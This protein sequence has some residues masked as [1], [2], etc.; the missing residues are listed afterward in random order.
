MDEVQEGGRAIAEKR[1]TSGK[2]GN[3]R[4][5]IV[6][7][8]EMCSSRRELKAAGQV[9]DAKKRQERLAFD[10]TD[11]QRCRSSH[12]GKRMT[13]VDELPHYQGCLSCFLLQ[14]KL[15]RYEVQYRQGLTNA[16]KVLG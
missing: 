15:R 10:G 4:L 9:C 6:M 2:I 7:R 16:G 11:D 3:S 5:L 8:T 14:P 12:T 1:R 13:P